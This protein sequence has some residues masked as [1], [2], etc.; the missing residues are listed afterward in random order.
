MPDNHVGLIQSI[1]VKGHLAVNN[2]KEGLDLIRR[3]W[4]WYINHPYGT[5]STFV[6]GYLADG[7][8]GYRAST[9]YGGDYSYTSHAHGW[10]TGPTEALTTYIVGISFTEPGGAEWRLAPQFG[11]LKHAE[12]GFINIRGKWHAKW[13]LTGNGYTVEWSVPSGT[14]GTIVLPSTGGRSPRSVFVDGKEIS[15]T[16]AGDAEDGKLVVEGQAG[17]HVIEVRV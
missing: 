6:E 9:A 3:A 2:T 13:A 8:F 16:G 5:N 11:D 12:A 10:S 1:E 17:R 4:G 7:S 14:K 15:E